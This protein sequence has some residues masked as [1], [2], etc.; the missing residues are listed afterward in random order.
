MQARRVVLALCLAACTSKE[1]APTESRERPSSSARGEPHTL[2]I[3]SYNV[4]YSLAEKRPGVDPSQWADPDT[5]RHVQSLDAHVL[6]LQETNEAWESAIRS[7]LS[8]R[9]PHCAF[10][11][12]KRFLPE[13]LGVCAR[14]P[15][16]VDATLESPVGW[17][18]AQRIRVHAPFGV[19]EILNVHL[20]PAVAA[21]EQW[22]QVHRETRPLRKQEVEGYLAHLSKGIPAIIVGDFN[23]IAEGD[24]FRALEGAGFENALSR[25]GEGQATWRWPGLAVP[26]EAQL[27]HVAY[28]ASAFSLVSAKVVNGGNSD[29]VPVVITLRTRWE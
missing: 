2:V 29:H 5:L 25:A 10:H 23:E 9:F 8:P 12:P 21:P 11:P 14:Y 24:L 16:D 6:V 19:V 15:L 1:G 7:V 22:W 18:P 13:G 4:L 3:A 28:D 27:D 26:L 17:F 20:R